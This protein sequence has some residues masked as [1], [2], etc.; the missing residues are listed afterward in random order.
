MTD[1]LKEEVK[2]ALMQDVELSEGEYR[3]KNEKADASTKAHGVKGRAALTENTRHK[4]I[5]MNFYGTA[6]NI[7]VGILA[8]V[9]EMNRLLRYMITGAAEGGDDDKRNE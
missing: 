4:R 8:E 1:N 6:L 2:K 5:Q 9:S 3:A 7:M